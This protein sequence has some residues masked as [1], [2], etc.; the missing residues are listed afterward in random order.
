MILG[1][2]SALVDLEVKIQDTEIQELGFAKGS[3][4]L[5][6]EQQSLGLIKKFSER[7]TKQQSGGSTANTIYG[8]S[9]YANYPCRLI[10]SVGNDQM[11]E[12]YANDL[13]AN[14]IDFIANKGELKTG[15]CLVLVSDDGQRTMLTYLGSAPFI[16]REQINDN[17][18]TGVKYFVTEGY[19]WDNEN[20]IA[21]VKHCIKI[22]K[23]KGIKFAFSASDSFCVSRHKED[24]LEILKE[25]DIFFANADEAKQLA[26]TE[27]LE[28]A[29]SF[30]AK[31]TDFLVVTNGEKGANLII[32]QKKYF[33]ISSPNLKVIDTTGAGDNFAAGVLAGIV[34]EKSIEDIGKLG[35]ELAGKVIVKYGA[36]I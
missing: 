8:I 12:F 33:F 29:M 20:T 25:S 11:G 2:G 30:L 22:I 5:I 18:F 28:D 24:F 27:N 34:Q 26:G 16:N 31:D 13:Q 9:K 36:R 35:T 23:E 7:I 21:A 17:T 6:D 19:L 10:G 32:E 3:M 4:N 1:M 15:I 14:N